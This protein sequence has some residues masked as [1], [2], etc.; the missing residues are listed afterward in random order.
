[1]NDNKIIVTDEGY[2]K[3]QNELKILQSEKRPKAVERLKKAR[4]MGDLSENSE[5]VAAKEELSFVD[6]RIAE[7]EETLRRAQ[8]TE[9]SND[10][11]AV[12]IGD[13]VIVSVNGETSAY[14]IVGEL[15]T[16]I[17][18]GKLSHKSP[19]G[20]ALLRKRKGDAI[21]IQIPAGFVEYKILD[22]K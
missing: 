11:S 2:K 10:K 8:I 20:K 3:L 17:T 7:I 4:E 1:M 16:D 14:T 18:N 15:E 12:E 5:Y 21:T 13:K 6:G 9:K 22:I 19:I